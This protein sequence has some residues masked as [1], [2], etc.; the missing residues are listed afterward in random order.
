MR[1]HDRLLDFFMALFALS[2]L[3]L[4]GVTFSG[5][6]FSTYAVLVLAVPLVSGYLV[7][8]NDR[9]RTSARPVESV[10]ECHED[11]IGLGSFVLFILLFLIFFSESSVIVVSLLLVALFLTIRQ[12]ATC[13]P[14]F[15][16]CS[17]PEKSAFS[18]IA[19]FAVA[20]SYTL[21]SHRPDTDD[22]LYLLI[23][24]L[25]L[26]QPHQAIKH[27]PTTLHAQGG[28]VLMSYPII[29]AVVSY[30]IGTDFMQVYYLFV[31]A[32]A[33]MLSVLA[34]HGLFRHVDSNRAALL[35]LMTVVVL[36][37]WGD[38]HRSPGNF[39]FV[40]LYHGKAIFYV[41]VCPYLVSSAI[42]VLTRL[43][44]SEFRLMMAAIS[45][46]GLV[47]S[48]IVLI[49]FFFAG[50]ILGAWLVYREPLRQARYL[51]F[52]A[53][54]AG[55]A[56][57]AA[58]TVIYLG[59]VP[60][61]D[62][63]KVEFREALDLSFGEGLRGAF[64]IASIG[65]LPLLAHD[66]AKHRALLATGAGLMLITL[67]PILVFLVG[68]VTFSLSWRLQWLLP[69]GGMVAAGILIV[70]DFISRGRPPLRILLCVLG[71]VGFAML[72]QTTF[73]S[74]NRNRID[75]PQ[76]KPPAIVDGIFKHD[77]R[78]SLG[79]DYR[80]QGGR[81]CLEHGCY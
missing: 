28:R 20:V 42:G 61:I 13:P 54:L 14:P 55:L 78:S 80:L 68:Q 15:T 11:R 52:L 36:I 31:P 30:W 72:G 26:D 35:T 6:S 60:I 7:M 12:T 81:I 50:V 57:L 62:S 34:W 58:A 10:A 21:I 39:A 1:I 44:G 27:L 53:G 70:A 17:A 46:V 41:V 69:I 23:G 2:T 49:P 63:H 33:A 16:P 24:T 22:T 18:L 43:P 76:I 25:P 65:L 40:R 4:W 38:E 47:H 19:A 29:E 71:L 51:P 3:V 77:R 48:A 32:L 5:G 75:V 56:A 8:V 9:G 66:A 59:R 73:S 74:S 45:G 67:N 64:G 79:I 37:L